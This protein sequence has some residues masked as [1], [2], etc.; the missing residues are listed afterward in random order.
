MSKI[1]LT[2]EFELDD[3]SP[4]DKSKY[5]QHELVRPSVRYWSDVW[6]RLKESKLAMFC[7][8]SIFILML[9]AIFAPMFS[10]YAFDQTN[11]AKSNLKPNSEH[12]FGTD[13]LGRDLWTRIWT[14]ARVSFIVGFIGAILPF[15]IGM[16]VGGIAGWFGGWVDMVSMRIIDIGL[17]IPPM[18]YIV[19]LII[20]FGGGV[21]SIILALALMGWMDAARTFRGRVLQFKNREFALAAKTLGASTSRIIYRHIMPNILGA[22]VVSLSASI[23]AAIF[24]EAGLSFIGLGVAPPATSLGQLAADGV[25]KYRTQFYQFLIP[26]VVI[27]YI[28]FVFFMFGNTLR[29]ALD[30][31]LR[32]ETKAFRRKQVKANG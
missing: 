15:I 20:Y 32:N 5:V 12:W 1:T 9:I 13:E 29:D 26:S 7:L 19:L 21:W 11:F 4:A 18:I 14:G 31:K 16:L 24:V 28:I 17:C 25:E 2:N 8:G 10:P 6:R 3:F 23:P 22:M 30:P 27:S